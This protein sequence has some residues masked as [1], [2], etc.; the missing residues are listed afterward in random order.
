MEQTSLV[1]MDVIEDEEY[2][3]QTKPETG[4]EGEAN[5]QPENLTAE[6][7]PAEEQPVHMLPDEEIS[8]LKSRWER[9]QIKFVDEPHYSVEQAE[10]LISNLLGRLAQ[11]HN[12]RG[13]NLEER[14]SNGGVSTEDLRVALLN[15]HAAF[16]RLIEA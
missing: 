15:Y 3:W 2:V 12:E 16:E 4:S 14:N 8:E 9:L 13:T 11:V 10:V 5:P 6:S 1:E 7:Q